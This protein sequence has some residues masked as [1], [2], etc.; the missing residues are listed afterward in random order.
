[1]SM[2]LRDYLKIFWRQRWLIIGLVVLATVTAWVVSASQPVKYGTSQSFAINRVNRDVTPDYQFDGYYALQ[3]ADLFSQTVVS[4][5]S[6]PSVLSE[7]YQQANLNPEIESLSS[8]PSRFKV[9]KYSSQN[10]VVRITERTQDRVNKVAAA[11]K[12]VMEQKAAQLNQTPEGKS[13][14]TIVGSAPVIAPV[15]PN[16]ILT[17]LVALVLS[18]GAS[19]FIAA[20]RHYLRS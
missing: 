19:L 10:I 13:Q 18:L 17:A 14:F 11:V 16:S 20:A 1:M 6:T 4:W 2:E 8:L 3:A 15:R 12:T 7:V 9:K 5:F